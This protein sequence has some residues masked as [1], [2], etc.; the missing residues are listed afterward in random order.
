[1]KINIITVFI[2]ISQ[3]SF[4]QKEKEISDET[5]KTLYKSLPKVDGKY[6]YS[7]IVQLDST[8]KKD[9]LYR[10]AKL[11][12]VDVF[13]SAKDVL[14]YDDRDEGKVIGKGNFEI[15]EM[16]RGFF[17]SVFDSWRVNFTLELFAKDGRYRY[18]IYDF[19]IKE[20]RTI[21]SG[22]GSPDYYS[23]FS[24]DDAYTQ[25]QK[26]EIKKMNKK[27]FTEIVDKINSTISEIKTYMSKKQSSSNSDF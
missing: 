8:Y 27:M 7:E 13:K 3:L 16:Q 5:I 20:K 14:Q 24:I 15:E 26:G 10:N 17:N 4:G 23:D 12:F 2:L 6:E 22:S 11:F 19:S 9:L 25:T 18:R 21:I 1:M